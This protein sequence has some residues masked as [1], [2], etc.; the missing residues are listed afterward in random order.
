MKA[1]VVVID[2][3]RRD[4]VGCYGSEAIHTPVLDQLA[5]ESVRFENPKPEALPTIQTR[6]AIHTGRRVFPFGDHQSFKGDSVR[7]PGWAPNP[8]SDVTIAEIMRNAGYHTGLV[9]DTYH[10]FKPSMNFH[11]GFEQFRWIRGQEQDCFESLSGIDPQA[12]A[13]HSYPAQHNPAGQ[14][15]ISRYLANVSARRYEEEYFAPRVF[16]EAMRFVEDNRGEDFFLMVDS[17]DPHE[18]FDPPWWYVDRYCP[19]YRGTDLIWPSYGDCG[20]L[21]AEQLGHIRAL[22]A[23]EVTMVDRWL[24]IF[25]DHCQDLGIMDETLLL[26]L[27]DHGHSL[28]D[29]GVLG[30]LPHSPYPEL[31]DIIF[32]ARRPGGAGGGQVC[33]S[34]IYTHDVAPTVAGQLGVEPPMPMHG[35]D[36]LAVAEGRAPGREY[37]VSGYANYVIYADSSHWYFSDHQRCDQHLYA[38]ADDPGC[39][40]N[41]A[42]DNPARC[43]QIFAIAR[44]EAGGSF[45]EFTPEQLR[46]AGPWYEMV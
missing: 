39:R 14:R 45:P 25:L 20:D 41:I 46:Q 40:S 4:H 43:D 36:V 6:R 10:Q 26:V 16:T 24:G 37:A 32:M 7:V 23:G 44:A 28:G 8:D 42:A 2:S 3:L 29:H 18:P 12:A 11:R 30:K 27:S 21:S 5:R 22:Y 9:T 1:I 38:L 19:G 15:R 35:R 31:V 34:F 17:F 33:D 13:A